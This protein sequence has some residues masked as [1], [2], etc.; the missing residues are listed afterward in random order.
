[1]VSGSAAWRDYTKIDSAVYSMKDNTKLVFFVFSNKLKTAAAPN[2][3]VQS[4]NKSTTVMK[5]ADVLT[6]STT[7]TTIPSTTITT[8]TQTTTPNTLSS[9]TFSA[10]IVDGQYV[11]LNKQNYNA[12]MMNLSKS[13]LNLTGVNQP[14]VFPSKVYGTVYQA[15]HTVFMTTWLA[16]IGYIMSIIIILL[17]AIFIGN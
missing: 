15:D 6:D 8:P 2:V 10:P 16:F 17:H 11:E 13:I 12:Y 3:T 9:P 1:M 4:F 5:V 14:I 7:T